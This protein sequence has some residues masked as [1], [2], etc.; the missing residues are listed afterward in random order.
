VLDTFVLVVRWGDGSDPQLVAVGPDRRFS[1]Q[2][3]YLNNLA[4]G[5]AYAVS[6]SVADN[7]GGA[8]LGLT[9][10]AVA[11]VAPGGVVLNSGSINEGGTF[12]LSGSFA[13]P[14]VLDG[15]T[16]VITWGDGS[17]PTTLALDPNVLTFSASHLYVD[18]APGGA[19]VGVTVTDSDGGAVAAGTTVAVANVAPTVSLDP[20][21]AISEGGVAT[22]SGVV[23]DP[24]VLDTFTVTVNW[25]DGGAAQTVAVGADRHFSAQHQYLNNP[26]GGG[27]FTI[28]VTAADNGGAAGSAAA[29]AAVANVAPTAAPLTGPRAGTIGQFNSFTGV[30]GLPLTFGSALAD[31]G[32]LDKLTVTWDFGDGTTQ[33]GPA[34]AGAVSAAHAYAATGT[35]TVRL[36]VRDGDGG[37]AT[38]SAT[39]CVSA[40]E[41]QADPLG[42]TALVVGG[43]AGNDTIK[44][45][46]DGSTYV[47]VKVNGVNLGT[48]AP[49][50]RVVVYGLAGDDTITVDNDLKLSAWLYGGDGNDTL[51]AGGGNDV[52][53]GGGGADTLLGRKGCDLLIGGAGCDSLTGN[54]DCDLLI[55]GTTAWDNSPA[56]LNQI[57]TCWTSSASFQSKVAA[58]SQG[59]LAPS[60]VFDDGAVDVLDGAAGRD[61]II[62]GRNDIVRN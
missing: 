12:T 15:H 52:L 28:G 17:A 45:T 33:T 25:G 27:S 9:S 37:T 51:T 1:A 31:P 14:G 34:A 10:A 48:F 3:T 20:V 60:N 21:A 44:V 57:M 46:A 55:G 49:T 35:Y 39:V 43:T 62:G 54:R 56:K 19:A 11:N 38:V 41:V 53:L 47:Q 42:G 23:S 18:D 26:A 24:G 58:L 4:G 59:L 16:V 32:T 5:A 6:V 61:W 8:G 29:T 7:G 22:L 2:H 13:D 30:R 50:N 36:T 40:A